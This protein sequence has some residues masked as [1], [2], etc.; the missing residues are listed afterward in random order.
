MG[1]DNMSTGTY[2]FPTGP[3]G[4]DGS[5][6]HRY[7]QCWV[8]TKFGDGKFPSAVTADWGHLVGATDG[9]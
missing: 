6:S 4:Q 8:G 5:K 3:L 9:A 7:I 2:G 1:R